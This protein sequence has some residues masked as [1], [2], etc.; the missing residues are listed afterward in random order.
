M[1]LRSV[2][3]SVELVGL[4]M[5]IGI[6]KSGDARYTLDSGAGGQLNV[7]WMHSP[8][9]D[10]Q[11]GRVILVVGEDE[12][13]VT[14]PRVLDI[15]GDGTV[16]LT[17]SE[18]VQASAALSAIPA[19]LAGLEGRIAVLEAKVALIGAPV[20]DEAHSGEGTSYPSGEWD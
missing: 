2:D 1:I 18:Y 9:V 11:S 8:C 17:L 12:L 6:P 19:K 10:G 20:P 13:V 4:R 5:S 3:G 16:S 7:S 14:S 15:T